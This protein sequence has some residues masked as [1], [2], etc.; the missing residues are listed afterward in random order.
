MSRSI[1]V[2][3]G[4]LG[5]PLPVRGHRPQRP[6]GRRDGATIR[7]GWQLPSTSAGPDE[8]QPCIL[9][10]VSKE[11]EGVE[12]DEGA[13]NANKKTAAQR[14]SATLGMR[15]AHGAERNARLPPCLC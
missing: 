15:S 6:S 14:L 12:K 5:A 1:W 13:G 2:R 10:I 3:S 8:P 4:V 11:G 7:T 9:G